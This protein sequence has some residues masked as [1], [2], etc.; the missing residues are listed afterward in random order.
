MRAEDDT[1]FTML[2]TGIPRD[3]YLDILS[4][5]RKQTEEEVI[6]KVKTVM[7]DFTQHGE[8]LKYKPTQY[9]CA[10]AELNINRSRSTLTQGYFVYDVTFEYETGYMFNHEEE[11]YLFFEKP[12]RTT[13]TQ[14][15]RKYLKG[16]HFLTALVSNYY[17]MK[18]EDGTWSNNY[19]PILTIVANAIGLDK[20]PSYRY[21]KDDLGP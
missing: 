10:T 17:I 5:P 21:S 7:Q 1:D 20:L 2:K 9:M 15:S 16:E 19:N 6:K 12:S 13:L 11:Y 4:G 18:N 14:F 3:D 8:P